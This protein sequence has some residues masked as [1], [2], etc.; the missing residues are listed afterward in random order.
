MGSSSKVI[1]VAATSLIVG[2]YAVSMKEVQTQQVAAASAEVGRLQDQQTIDAAMRSAIDDYAIKDGGSDS[3]GTLTAIDGGRFTYAVSRSA[4]TLTVNLTL[5]GKKMV[6]T[7][8][9]TRTTG[10]V[11]QGSRKIHRGKWEVGSAFVRPE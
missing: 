3:Q 9:L 2:T 8:A 10:N 5:G 7:A 1:L 11:K 6:A 4:K